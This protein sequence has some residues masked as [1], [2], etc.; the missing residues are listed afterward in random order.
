MTEFQKA[1]DVLR[2]S[3]IDVTMEYDED[4]IQVVKLKGNE[5]SGGFSRNIDSVLFTED[6]LEIIRELLSGVACGYERTTFHYHCCDANEI[7]E[8]IDKHLSK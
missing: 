8:K 1:V 3:G 5:L 6:E 7:I 4:E 2:D